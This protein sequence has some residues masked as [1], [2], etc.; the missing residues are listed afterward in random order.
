MAMS[1]GLSSMIKPALV[2]RRH[3]DPSLHPQESVSNINVRED[4]RFRECHSEAVVATGIG[5][6]ERGRVQEAQAVIA[7]WGPT[8]I[9]FVPIGE[10]RQ[11]LPGA[12]SHS[13]A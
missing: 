7:S 10:R 1:R 13:T 6:V 9:T 8:W 2:G 5:R 12:R 4:A 3:D 11:R